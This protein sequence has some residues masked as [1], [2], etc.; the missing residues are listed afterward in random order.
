MRTSPNFT[1][2]TRECCEE[3]S[4]CGTMRAH[5]SSFHCFSLLSPWVKDKTYS[6]SLNPKGITIY[7]SI[8]WASQFLLWFPSTPLSRRT[9]LLRLCYLGNSFISCWEKW[10]KVLFSWTL[11]H[12]KP[13]TP[14]K[15]PCSCPSHP[16]QDGLSCKKAVSCFCVQVSVRKASCKIW[17]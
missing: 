6:E 10:Q 1:A 9:N 14:S 2:P 5:K 16:S 8:P 4:N 12:A 3:R 17:L 15:L 7:I 11:V 13:S